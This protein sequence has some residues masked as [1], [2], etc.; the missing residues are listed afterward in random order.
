VAGT[1]WTAVRALLGRD[2]RRRA[3]DGDILD[4]DYVRGHRALARLQDL[5]G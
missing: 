5:R 1:W 3:A 4:P 2:R